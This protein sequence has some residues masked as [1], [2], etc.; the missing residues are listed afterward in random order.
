MSRAQLSEFM[1]ATRLD[2][3]LRAHSEDR[4][5]A[6]SREAAGLVS[7]K[8]NRSPPKR[9]PLIV[10][11]GP[12]C[13]SGIYQRHEYSSAMP[14]GY[15]VHPDALEIDQQLMRL[16]RLKK[17]ILSSARFHSQEALN[18][19]AKPLM[20][21]LTYRDDVDW[22]AQ[23]MSRYINS[24]KQWQIRTLKALGRPPMPLRYV[25]VYEHTKRNRPHYHVLFWVP[26]GLTMPKADKRGW[27]P[28]G[29]TRT[30]WARH[31]VGYI[32]KYASKGTEGH[33]PK[34][35]R[36]YGVGGLSERSRMF[37]AWWN[38]PVSIRK[39]GEPAAKWRRAPGGGWVCR[40]DGE[41]RPSQWRVIL[42]LGRVFVLPR[43][44]PT[45]SPFDELRQ[46]LI[47]RCQHILFSISGVNRRPLIS[48]FSSLLILSR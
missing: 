23:Q 14:V 35:V 4:E 12:S 27:W 46:S 3:A 44:A 13:E 32:S 5:N 15:H 30:E 47:S 28:H 38:L 6:A 31:A 25:W 7:I 8:T 41:W 33:I 11:T 10:V 43:P 9:K 45:P 34:G 29:N 24:V 42:S 18:H 22:T 2:N 17:N 19:R 48:D 26:K 21:T 39:W 40:R 1:E 16:R 36:L 37:K 20:V